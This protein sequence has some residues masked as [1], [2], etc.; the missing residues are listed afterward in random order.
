MHIRKYCGANT[1][2]FIDEAS[3]TTPETVIRFKIDYDNDGWY[4]VENI[5]YSKSASAPKCHIKRFGKF[6]YLPLAQKRLEQEVFALE[7]NGYF[8]FNEVSKAM[9]NLKDHV[10]SFEEARIKSSDMNNLLDVIEFKDELCLQPLPMGIH[11]FL[12]IDSFGDPWIKSIGWKGKRDWQKLPYSNINQSIL[13]TIHIDGCNGAIFE[14]FYNGHKFL[15]LDVVYL[16]DKIMSDLSQMQRLASLKQYFKT[17]QLN[18]EYL[19]PFKFLNFKDVWK[20][21]EQQSDNYI[22]SMNE[23]TTSL[24]SQMDAT[25]SK[26]SITKVPS[27]EVIIG[28][29]IN[30]DHIQLL[31]AENLTPLQYYFF[32]FQLDFEH[33]SYRLV[34]HDDRTQVTFL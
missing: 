23:S 25:Y 30:A 31:R 20:T 24:A 1:V 14:G 21:L 12:L 34:L 16:H 10:N 29:H 27:T 3:L 26:Y 5:R 22:L 19:L 6:R 33:L 2:Y 17:H 18:P 11:S 7:Q 13:K 8:C 9:I 4:S 32:P 28:S 15:V